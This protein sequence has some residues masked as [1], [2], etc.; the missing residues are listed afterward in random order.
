MYLKNGQPIDALAWVEYSSDGS[1]SPSSLVETQPANATS[2]QL[3]AMGVTVQADPPPPPPGPPP[4]PQ[5][6]TA[7]QARLAL[8]AAGKRSAVEGAVAAASQ[9][10]KDYWEFC[11]NLHRQHPVLLQMAQGLGWTSADLDALF[12]A[13]AAL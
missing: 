5:Q 6:V 11:A 10:V 2:A 13:A 8:N 1:G 9:D 7:V 4:V 3:V 12:T